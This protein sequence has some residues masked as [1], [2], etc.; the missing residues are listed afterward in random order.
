MK[1]ALV[2]TPVLSYPDSNLRY[3]MDTDASAEGVGGVVML[4]VKEGKE[5]LVAYFSAKFSKPKRNYCLTRKELAAVMKSLDHFYHFLY[6][7]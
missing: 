4:Q 5:W 3:L 2:N 6:G 7:D 1:Q